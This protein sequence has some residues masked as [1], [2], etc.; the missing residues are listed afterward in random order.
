MFK[1][2]KRYYIYIYIYIITQIKV[3]GRDRVQKKCIQN[4]GALY[5]KGVC[6]NDGNPQE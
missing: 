5:V 1:E 3:A 6:V 4:W 2:E